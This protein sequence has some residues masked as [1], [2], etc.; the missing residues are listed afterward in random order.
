VPITGAQGSDNPRA[1]SIPP[2]H[3]DVPPQPQPCSADSPAST[4]AIL[5]AAKKAGLTFME[6]VADGDLVVEGLDNLAPDD[7]QKL[8]ANLGAVRSELLPCDVSTA[9]L[10][11]LAKLGIE[12]AYVDTEERAA[13]EVHRICRLS[14]MLGL[15][16]ETAPLP[17]FLPKAGP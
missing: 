11:L 6:R 9:S 15:D 10:D 16:I 8:Q 13:M 3:V 5:A 2:F 17:K 4:T 12:V 7:R 1:R 14:T